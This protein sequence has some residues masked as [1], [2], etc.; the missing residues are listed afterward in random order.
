MFV[1]IAGIEYFKTR[2]GKIDQEADSHR[3]SGFEIVFPSML[4]KAK[5]LGLDLPYELPLINQIMGKREAKLKRLYSDHDSTL[6]LRKLP[7]IKLINS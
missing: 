3:P 1:H 5:I 6:L 7:A 4:K 2:A